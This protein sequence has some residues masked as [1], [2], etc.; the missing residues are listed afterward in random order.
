[1]FKRILIANRGEIALRVIH[2]CRALGVETVAVYSQ[3][4]ADSP[5]VEAADQAVC[6]GGPRSA[7]S[8]LDMTAI[9]QAADQTSAQAIH[10]GYGFL[11]ENALFADLCA[12]AKRT[13]IGPPAQ[14]IRA[15]G[16]KAAAR[17]T[18]KTAGIPVIPGTE[19]ILP[20]AAEGLRQAKAVGF[21]VLLKAT[22][23]GGGRGMRACRDEAEFEP[24]FAQASLEAEKSF[25]N[26]GL[27]L[28]K[29]IEGGRHIEFQFMA[30]AFGHVVHLGERECSVQRHHQKLVEESPSA[31]IDARTREEMGAKVCEAVRRMGYV[32][33]GTME[34]LRDPDGRIYFMEVNTR[35]QVEHPVT[36]MVTG[37]D[38][39]QE[40]IR[41]ACNHTLSFT[42]ADARLSGHAIECRINAE[43]PFDAFRPSPG[44]VTRF[45]PPRGIDGVR[46]RLDTHVQRGYRVP[47]YYDSMIGK[48]IVAGDNRESARKG[49]L[50][51]LSRLGIE[52][53]KTTIPFLRCIL[54]D[55]RFVSGSYDTR[56][57]ER[58]LG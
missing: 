39:V 3:A 1:M 14:V 36:E 29:L 55:A 49:M 33:A 2:A 20:D 53:I 24:Q 8:Y 45:E 6:I 28:E 15:M 11:S 17:Q 52:G 50:E 10:P 54:E 19:D 25:S 57:A 41:V 5:H 46:V 7:E 4:D 22:A 18:M 21:P 48:L 56:L 44:E 42:Q 23:G 38:L 34:F 16:D 13:F 47:V 51:A 12:L 35:L 40:Q 32:G 27:Y 9:L 43:D 26:A 37:L 58:I 30:D 31:V